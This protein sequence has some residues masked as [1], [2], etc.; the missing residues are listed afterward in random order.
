MRLL[1]EKERLT[2]TRGYFG[3]VFVKNFYEWEQ[4]FLSSCYEKIA[5]YTCKLLSVF[6]QTP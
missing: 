2:T 4:L 5:G 6:A 3:V 1:N